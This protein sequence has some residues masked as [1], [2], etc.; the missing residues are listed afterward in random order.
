MDILNFMFASWGHFLGCTLWLGMICSTM[1]KR[2]A[3]IRAAGYTLIGEAGGGS[4]D[5]LERPRVDHAPTQ[6]KLLW[7]RTTD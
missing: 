5:R 3:S 6:I 4:W 2:G 7:E 1:T